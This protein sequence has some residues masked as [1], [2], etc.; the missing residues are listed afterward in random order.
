MRGRP[1]PTS[2]VVCLALCACEPTPAPPTRDPGVVLEIDGIAVTRADIEEYRDYFDRIDPQMGRMY[3]ARELLDRFLLPL[4]LARRE[5]PAER[6]ALRERASGLRQVADN[7]IALR[8]KGALAGGQ[9]NEHPA[10]RNSLPFPVSRFAFDPQNL[11]AVSAPIEVP[12]GFVLVAPE[13]IDPGDTPVGDLLTA[14][15]VP[16]YTHDAAEFD[17][18]LADTKA[19]LAGKVTFVHPDYEKALP[20]W[21]TP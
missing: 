6:S 4:A 18:W 12:Q 9:A 2:V 13:R 14:F 7:A 11:G 15:F 1:E 8:R 17:A 3:A 16:F 5:F 10:T 21:L 20:R 19:A